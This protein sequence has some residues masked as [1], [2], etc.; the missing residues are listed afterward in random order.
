MN[1]AVV[2][3]HPY[4]HLVS[5][6]KSFTNFPEAIPYKKLLSGLLLILSR[7]ELF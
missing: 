2:F 7:K 3:A 1:S 4:N 6:L 5:G